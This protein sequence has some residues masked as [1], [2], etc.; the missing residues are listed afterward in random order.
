MKGGFYIFLILYG[1][2]KDYNK[3]KR[4]CVSF[5]KVVPLCKREFIRK[6][7]WL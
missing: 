1:H 5:Y 3:N 4:A 7:C 2:N 6:W